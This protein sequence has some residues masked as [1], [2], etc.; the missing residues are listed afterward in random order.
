M[1][2]ISPVTM[3]EALEL[4]APRP[5]WTLALLVVYGVLVL[6]DPASKDYIDSPITGQGERPANGT[7]VFISVYLDR[8]LEVDQQK[9]GFQVCWLIGW[10]CTPPL[11]LGLGTNTVSVLPGGGKA[12][13]LCRAHAWVCARNLQDV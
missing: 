1:D 13:S 7:T 8:L 5:V 2:S 6:G 11:R 10:S 9:Y 4:L 3:G 12:T